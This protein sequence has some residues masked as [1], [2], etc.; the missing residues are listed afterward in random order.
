MP[1][2]VSG[3]CQRVS[4][5]PGSDGGMHGVIRFLGGHRGDPRLGHQ[6]PFAVEDV[7]RLIR[8]SAFAV[9]LAESDPYP[10]PDDVTDALLRDL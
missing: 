7:V 2:D 8:R 9:Q 3:G 6:R 5:P 1:V 10:I 4:D